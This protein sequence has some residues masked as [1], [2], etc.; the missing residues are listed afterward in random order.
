M[1]FIGKNPKWNTGGFTPQSTEPANPVEGMVYYDDGTNRAEGLYVYKN[2]QWTTVGSGSSGINYIENGDAEAGTTGWSIYA[3]AA[4]EA[5]VDGTGGSP[6]V[7]LTASTSS[8]LRGVSSLLIT[9]DAANRQGEGASYDFSIDDADR[10]KVLRISFDYDSSANYA[11]GDFRVYIYDV[12]NSQIIEV[13]DRDL[14]ANDQGK[15]IGEFQTASDSNSYR[16]II[17]VSSTNASA[18]S[19]KFDNVQVGPR[20]IARGSVQTDWEAY[21]PTV[22]NLGSGGTNNRLGAFRRDGDSLECQ[23]YIQKDGTNGTGSTE[24]EFSIPDGLVIDANKLASGAANT[25]NNV[26][27]AQFNGS[28]VAQGVL[29]GSTTTV[30]IIGTGGNAMFGSDFNASGRLRFFFKVPIVGWSSNSEISTDFG[31]RIIALRYRDTSGQAVT[32]GNIVNFAT[33]IFDTTKSWD[34]SEF[35][36]PESGIYEVN[37]RMRTNNVS[38]STDQNFGV[39][40][41]LNATTYAQVLHTVVGSGSANI[42][43]SGSV[44][45][46]MSKGDTLDLE[47]NESISPV[48]LSAGT[49][50]NF[51]EIKKLQSPQTLIGSEVVKARYTSDAGQTINSGVTAD[52]VFEDVVY[53]SHNAYN[54]ST[55]EYTVPVSGTYKLSTKNTTNS[56]SAGTQYRFDIN[57]LVN[58]IS[59]TAMFPSGTTGSS[60][61]SEFFHD[62]LELSKG[63]VVKITFR[64]SAATNLSFQAVGIRNVF[65]ISKI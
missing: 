27:G 23:V 43:V 29:V 53:D 25:L 56:F 31:N 35:T 19:V 22:T 51:L 40:V 48:N 57:V 41:R 28:F 8:P 9:K 6:T 2:G 34:G 24:V 3:D 60:T 46:E 14:P 30:K 36:A 44:L 7:T 10:A 54:T 18:T 50:Q 33:E 20:D 64:N 65:T 1:A 5:P 11:D 63:D 59:Q 42:D 13:V 37:L 55:G 21:T 4:G 49:F 17:H 58:G 26:G 61:H 52:L 12:T 39:N 45:V 62:E 47:F 38:V 15:Y 32:S 16:L